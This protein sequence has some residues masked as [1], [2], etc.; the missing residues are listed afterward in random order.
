MIVEESGV[1]VFDT[2]PL[3]HFAVEGW[4]GPLK[5]IVGSRQAVVP[6]VVV[7]ELGEA[8]ARDARTRVILEQVWL[9]RW[10]ITSPAEHQAFSRYSELLVAG[11][12]NR[13]EAGVLALAETIAGATAVLDDLAARKAAK[14]HGVDHVGTLALL[15]EAIR[16]GLLTVKLVSAL[17]DDLMAGDYRLPFGRG[18]F[19]KWA[20]ENGLIG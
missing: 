5:H 13:G 16:G 18:G 8:A 2:G 10:E 4:M 15:C 3:V 11:K 1:L 6:D 14:T 19:E 20:S 12:R 7:E 17:A 9:E